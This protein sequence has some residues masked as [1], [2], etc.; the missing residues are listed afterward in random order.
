MAELQT[1]PTNKSV[2]DFLD[3]LDDE[4][5]RDDCRVVL[6]LMREAT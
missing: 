2:D 5:R 6:N 4:T 3:K 1:Q